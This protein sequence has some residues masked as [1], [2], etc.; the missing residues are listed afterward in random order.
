MDLLF[1][2]GDYWWFYAGFTAFVLALL[3]MDLGVFHRNAHVV[4]FRESL[5]W[6]IVWISLALLFGAGLYAYAAAK[7]GPELGSRIGLEFL[8][9]YL[10]EKSLAVDNVFVFVLVFTYFSI[11][12]QYQHRVL[13]YGILGALVFRAIFVALGSVLMQYWFVVAFFGV[14]LIATG[15]KMLWSPDQ[16]IEPEKN[17]V[18]RLL[19]RVVPITDRM[20][21][22]QFLVRLNGQWHATP[23]FEIGRAHV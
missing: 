8:T 6:S 21:G 10:V 13:F 11:P 22:Q 12:P 2:F 15:I 9:G 4:S 19:R 5:T 7:F 3:A 14:L 18:V 23:L 1:P 17:P 16:K 20:H